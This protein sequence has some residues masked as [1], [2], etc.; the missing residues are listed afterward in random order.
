MLALIGWIATTVL[1]AAW[2]GPETGRIGALV[3]SQGPE[4]AEVQSRI[5]RIFLV[6]RFDLTLL[7]LIVVDMV[8]KP[9]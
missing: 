8:I 6:S 5:A 4:S 3:E 1:G 7:L 9:T 2:L